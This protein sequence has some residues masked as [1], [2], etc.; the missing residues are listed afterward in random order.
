M[1]NPL[2]TVNVSVQVAPTPSQLQKTGAIVSQGATTTSPGTKTFLTKA[3]DL[4]ALLTPAKAISSITWTGGVATVT[5]SSPHGFTSAD[6]LY[7]TIAGAAPTGYNGTFLCTVTGASTFTYP[8]ASNPGSE[9]TAGTYIPAEVASV[10][11]RVTTF[12]AQGSGQGVYILECG[13][14]N[15]TDGVNF[16]SAWIGQN[17]GFFYSYLVPRFW[18]G[19]STF[20]TFLAT[21]TATTAKTYFF[22]TTTLAT[23]TDYANLKCVF[24]LIEAPAYGVWPSNVLT[25]LSYSGGQATATTTTNHGIAVGQWFQIA[26][27][28]PAGYNGWWQAQVG[29][30][31]DT[32]VWNIPTNPGGE[33]VLG[34]L[35]ASQYSSAGI[36]STEFSAAAPFQVTLNYAPSSTNRV[37]PLNF[38][39]L[40]DVTPFPTQGN[41]TLLST[42]NTANV[43]VI[44][45]GAQGG[46][47]EDVLIGGNLMDG[48]QFNYWYSVDWAQINGQQAVTAAVIN[49][50]NN[51][52]NPLYYNQDG[53]NALQQVL[54]TVMSNG[55]S[56]GL[57]LNP[58]KLTQLP[59]AQFAA[60][61]ALGTYDGFTVVNA[62]P[63]ASYTTENPNDYAA[64]KYNGLAVDYVPQL[65]FESITFNITVS[66]FAA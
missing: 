34:T 29:T 27:C 25:A 60:A 32:L 20:L 53:I 9:T 26:G 15:A 50:S 4:T 22:V 52:Q 48:N 59:A 51:P 46:I 23:Y 38:A 7:L 5:T 16:L 33:S 36:P 62:D 13:P 61:L 19:N 6:T 45:T 30:T 41:S 18:D 1:A 12:F 64:G 21:L 31:G 24:A 57:V 37:T 58:I 39:Y 44:G 49:G 66:S 14:G 55:V 35:L 42:L 3:S 10:T 47:S 11:A 8:L 40:F 63:F 43:N 65:G 28:T 54:S 2:V 17:P 56:Y